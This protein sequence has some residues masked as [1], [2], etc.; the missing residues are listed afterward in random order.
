MNTK[1]IL[2][3][4]VIGAMLTGSV[5]IAARGNDQPRS[6]ARVRAAKQTTTMTTSGNT[7]VRTRHMTASGNTAVQTRQ[8]TTSRNTAVRT[9][10]GNGRTVFGGSIFGF[11]YP[12]YSYY[13]FPYFPFA[14]SPP[15]TYIY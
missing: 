15:P 2:T 12:N 3:S 4:V 13:A 5:A 10:I 9:R 6:K 8:M 14:S 7:A 11:A 1:S